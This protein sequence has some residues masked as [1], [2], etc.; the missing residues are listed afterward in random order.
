MPKMER[1][2]VCV[3]YCH[4]NSGCRL[5][6]IPIAKKVCLLGVN[7]VGFDFSGCGRSEG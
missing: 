1:S 6:A 2:S 4:G 3:L 7:V 5:E